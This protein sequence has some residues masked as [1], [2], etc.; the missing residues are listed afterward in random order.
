MTTNLTPRVR[1]FYRMIGLCAYR[2]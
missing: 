1:N 2:V